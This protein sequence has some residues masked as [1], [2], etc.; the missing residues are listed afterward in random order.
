M[1]IHRHGYRE[2]VV[3]D[4]HRHR[5]DRLGRPI[6]HLAVAMIVHEDIQ[7][8]GGEVHFEIEILESDGREYSVDLAVGPDRKVI[9]RG[10]Q[11]PD[12][13]AWD[14]DEFVRHGPVHAVN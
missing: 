13:E 12:G 5:G 11:L 10:P 4:C 3:A 8:A 1:A 14:R 9:I 2:M 7:L 6:Y